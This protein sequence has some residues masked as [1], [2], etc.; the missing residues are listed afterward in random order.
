MNGRWFARV[1]A[2]LWLAVGVGAQGQFWEEWQAVVPMEGGGCGW[3]PS[4]VAVLLDGLDSREDAA[5]G[6]LAG[7]ACVADGPAAPWAVFTDGRWR[8]LAEEGW[9]DSWQASHAVVSFVSWPEPGGC[10]VWQ[11]SEGQVQEIRLDHERPRLMRTLV[12]HGPAAES[13]R[14]NGQG[15]LWARQGWVVYA[16]SGG[17]LQEQGRLPADTITWGV[18]GEHFWALREGGVLW[19]PGFPHPAHVPLLTMAWPVSDGL[20]MKAATGQ[21]WILAAGLIEALP[22]VPGLDDERLVPGDRGLLALESASERRLLELVDHDWREI[23]RVARPPALL[24]RWVSGRRDWRLC[25]DGR[26]LLSHNGTTRLLHQVEDPVSLCF[27]GAGPLCISRMEVAAFDWTGELLDRQPLAMARG[28]GSRE[29][30]AVL[31]LEQHLVVLDTA[32]E[33]PVPVAEQPLRINGELALGNRWAV[34]RLGRRLELLDLDP[35]WQPRSVAVGLAPSAEGELLVLEDRLL[36]AAPEGLQVLNLSNTGFSVCDEP[37]VRYPFRH[38]CRRG[39]DGLLGVDAQ[40]RLRQMRLMNNLPVS[41]EWEGELPLVGRL[42]IQRD[43][44]RVLSHGAALD[45]PL[46]A[47]DVLRPR[48]SPPAHPLA[49]ALAAARVGTGWRIER[50]ADLQGDLQVELVDIRG[51]RRGQWR[52]PAGEDAWNV[53][54]RGLAHGVY[55]LSLRAPDGRGVALRLNTA[56]LD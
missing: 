29:D 3:G 4:H 47:P 34:I 50:P 8:H 18:S 11:A 55:L 46:P 36:I 43:S 37:H 51:A 6:T 5:P 14:V 25:R 48:V 24:D 32:E 22:D 45:W 19:T 21:L 44:L 23:A 40:G 13:L 41:V 9:S 12:M 33:T 16:E 2:L 49:T 27:A 10:R 28:A 30:H 53:D 52:M 56:G 54:T 39:P 35:P 42:S 20:V 15:R 17:R 38:L 26:L 7:V 1:A 31:T